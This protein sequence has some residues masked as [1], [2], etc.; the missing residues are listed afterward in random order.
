MF[1]GLALNEKGVI[2]LSTSCVVAG[3]Q[4]AD[5]S[6]GCVA[7]KVRASFYNDPDPLI[8]VQLTPRSRC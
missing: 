1:S 7:K 5:R 8:S 2:P 6:F 4:V 3:G